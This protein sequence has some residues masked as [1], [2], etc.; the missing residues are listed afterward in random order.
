[1]KVTQIETL[2]EV[3]RKLVRELGILQ[4]DQLDS[5]MTPGHWHAL[6]E[7]NRVSDITI[8]NLAELLLMSVSKMSRIVKYLEKND[9]IELKAG[10]D[11][12][13]KYLH[14][15]LKGKS[16]IKKIDKFS[17]SKVS[18]A[19]EFLDDSEMLKIIEAIS[20]Y[21]A[22]LEKSRLKKEQIKIA[23]LSTSRPLRQQIVSMISNIQKNEF[24]IPISKET[25]AGILKA[26]QEYYYN[27]S[28][29]FWYAVDEQGKII[30][31]I[32]LKKID[33]KTGEVKKFFV[34]SEY[35]GKGV[36]Q[37]L[38][39]TLLKASVKHGFRCLYLGTVS[40]LHAAQ[41]FYQK[42]GFK[43]ISRQDLPENFEIC[44]LDSRFF[45]VE[46]LDLKK[47]LHG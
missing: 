22:A 42:Y 25:N 6:I 47:S 16:E 43:S 14:T 29:N 44:P 9:W 37:K 2:R 23:T 1:M 35:R 19:F 17:I 32:G 7:I 41:K 39:D 38:M 15:T 30:G 27:N 4:V 28:Y 40:K 46:V 11:K 33:A 26:E 12:R 20:K 24:S 34:T 10:I 36:A 18:G 3:S 45:K 8:S 31:S 5:N 21:S 13:E